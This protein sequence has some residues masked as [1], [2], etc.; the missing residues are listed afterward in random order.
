MQAY[1]DG[2]VVLAKQGIDPESLSIQF[3]EDLPKDGL[4]TRFKNMLLKEANGKSSLFKMRLVTL[5]GMTTLKEII[6]YLCE[7]ELLPVE[8]IV[9]ACLLCCFKGVKLLKTSNEGQVLHAVYLLHFFD[10]L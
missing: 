3:N 9:A 4:V 10:F 8:D 1:L 2:A 7:E 5:S 6:E